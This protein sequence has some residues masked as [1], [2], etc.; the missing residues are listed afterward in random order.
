[1]FE[2]HSHFNIQV[3]KSMHEWTKI[4]P[5]PK[6][7]DIWATSGGILGPPDM[8]GHFFANLA[9]SLYLLHN[10]LTSYKKN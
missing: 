4:L 1:M 9:L 2:N 6:K 7:P 5:K 8:M 3:K 10:N